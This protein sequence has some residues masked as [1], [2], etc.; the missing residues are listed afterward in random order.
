M[1]LVLLTHGYFIHEDPLEQKIMK[2]YPPLGMLCISAYLSAQ[3]INNEVFDST[4]SNKAAQI[5][6]VKRMKPKYIGF[7]VNL[8][9]KVNVIKQIKAIRALEIE[10]LKIFL[11]G[12]DVR[13]N[14]E[15]YLNAGADIIVNGEGEL[16]TEDLIRTLERNETLENVKGIAYQ[17]N[18]A[19]FK[20]E[21]REL[22]KTY[23]ELPFPARD[24]IDLE[25]YLKAWKDNHGKS[26]L[27]VSTQRGCPYT[28]KWCSTAVYGQS[29][30]RRSANLVVNELVHLKDAY[31][32][33]AFWFVDDVFTVSHK[34][35]KELHSEVISRKVK[36]EFEC[37]TRAERLTPEI[38]TILKEIGCFRIWIG[39]ESG[40]QK[41]IDKMD[42]RVDVNV[43]R[44]MIRTTRQHG[45]EA[46]TFIMLGYPDETYSDIKE[47]IHHLKSSNPD[48]FTITVSY[49]IVGTSLHAELNGQFINEPDWE[50][51]TDRDLDFKRTYKR[52]F[53]DYAVSRV[54]NEVN[55]NKEK[56]SGKGLS[57]KA[58]KYKAKSLLSLSMMRIHMLS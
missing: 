43:V 51:S 5:E 29:Y 6:Y 36:L 52:K 38:L 40:S 10:G 32:V 2:P 16:T 9:T 55:Y 8:M 17:L 22:S 48:Q 18:G 46:G 19:Q 14:W 25:P 28:C 30:R 49:P 24:R 33:D 37:I 42:R 41:I 4:F 13:Y 35:L 47:T 21:E 7:Y 50:N 1:S 53:Y 12:P 56:Q 39:A 44:D 54:V 58:L 27:N 34:W 23:D 31:G 15:K 57:A 26:M 45:I 3:G 20:N 11:G